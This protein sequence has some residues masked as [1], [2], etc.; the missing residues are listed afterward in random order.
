MPNAT[1]GLNVAIQAAG[2]ATWL[3]LHVP[4]VQ[5]MYGMCAVAL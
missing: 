3:L 1:T 4:C 5:Y 2:A